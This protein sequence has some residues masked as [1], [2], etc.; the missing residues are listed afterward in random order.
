METLIIN[1]RNKK[2]SKE[3]IGYLSKHGDSINVIRLN[4]QKHSKI[5]KKNTGSFFD[6]A[7]IW[8]DTD[9]TLDKIRE[10]AW[11]QI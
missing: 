5:N 11:R 6:I 1:I 8:K 9:I 10:K 7:G 3:L 2:I 4:S